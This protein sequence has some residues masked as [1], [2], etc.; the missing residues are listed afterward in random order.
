MDGPNTNLVLVCQLSHRLACSIP[1]RNLPLLTMA[2]RRLAPE[3][4]PAGFRTLDPFITPRSDQLALKF[5]H[6]AHDRQDQLA[7][8]RRGVQPRVF[9]C[10]DVCS[11]RLDFVQ[12]SE[13]IADGARA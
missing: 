4:S 8:W 13:Q 9:Q 5:C 3:Y 12:Q 7:M 11:G 6:S 2:Q 10:L 1:L